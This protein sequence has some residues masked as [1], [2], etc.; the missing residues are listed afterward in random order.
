MSRARLPVLVGAA[1]LLDRELDPARSAAP[2]DMLTEVARTAAD[3]AGGGDDLLRALDSI[4]LVEILGWR[5]A[6]GPR[7]LGERL[8]C[9]KLGAEY[10]CPTGGETPVA[11][12]N[13]MAERIYRGQSEIALVAGCNNVKTLRA[14]HK[15]GFRP[16]WE[17]GGSGKPT[18][19][20]PTRPGSSD[21]E[22]RYGLALPPEIYP[23]FENALRVARGLDLE[24]HRKGMGELM[25]SFTRVAA[26]NPDAWFPVERTATELV[27]V[28]ERN[29]M[30]AFPY[31]KYLNAFL[32]TDQAAAVLLMSQAKARALKIP[33][34]KWVYWRGGASQNEAQWFASQRPDFAKCPAIRACHNAA[35]E[36]AGVE[37][38]QIDAFDFYSCF[39]VAVSMAC[40]MLGIPE[41]D[42]R[43]FTVTGG[44]PY[45]GGP[46]SAYSLHALAA[47]M[48]RIVEG[49]VETGLV[50]GNGWYLTKHAAVVLAASPGEASSEPRFGDVWDESSPEAK[51][52]EVMIAQVA[53]G[54]ATVETYTMVFDRE[55]RPQRGIVIGRL[56]DGRRFLANTP[57]DL[58]L[59]EQIVAHELIGRRGRVWHD[60]DMNRF[61]PSPDYS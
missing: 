52:P 15:A 36:R 48:D 23:I 37:L 39:P 59:N 35:L 30:V 2:L 16:D 47:M 21:E 51:Q 12:I 4:A 42:P 31:P 9:E 50:T 33:Q 43:D 11:L 55:G 38:S 1:Q 28:S 41:D 7:L 19:I 18:Q 34:D 22:I 44:L 3:R 14:A 54:N 29:R 17:K 6:N 13:L 32:D 5:P 26:Q 53:N 49:K 27:T 10:V 46:A 25:S 20:G 8:G 61:D 60:E 40:E 58:A 24:Q 56:D 45:A 57:D